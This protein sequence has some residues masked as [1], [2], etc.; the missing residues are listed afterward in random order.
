[1]GTLKMKIYSKYQKCAKRITKYLN[2]P[3]VFKKPRFNITVFGTLNQS[4]SDRV[5]ISQKGSEVDF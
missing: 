4:I 5:P 1:M 3:Q 2:L